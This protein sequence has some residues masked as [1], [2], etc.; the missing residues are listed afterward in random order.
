MLGVNDVGWTTRVLF[1]PVVVGYYYLLPESMIADHGAATRS[2]QTV[3]R[4]YNQ[5]Q[6]RKHLPLN[7]RQLRYHPDLGY[8]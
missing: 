2:L 6:A 5:M 7:T 1:V 3:R 8:L 4:M